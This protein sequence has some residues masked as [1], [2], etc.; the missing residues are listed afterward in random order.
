MLGACAGQNYFAQPPAQLVDIH[1]AAKNRIT[2][3]RYFK[4]DWRY[5]PEGKQAEGN[6]AVFAFTVWLDAIKAGYTPEKIQ[7]CKLPNGE[8]HAYTRVQGWDLDVRYKYPIQS[9]EQDCK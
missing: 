5:I 7:I 8:G 2:Y 6:C 3:N 1:R 4:R 9:T